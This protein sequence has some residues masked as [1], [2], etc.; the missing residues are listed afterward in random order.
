MVVDETIKQVD[1]RDFEQMKLFTNYYPQFNYDII[2]T[3]IKK[4]NKKSNAR[5]S[6]RL[7][8]NKEFVNANAGDLRCRKSKY[9]T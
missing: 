9:G 4:K 8:L 6:S 2:I 7:M 3:K 1:L 5:N